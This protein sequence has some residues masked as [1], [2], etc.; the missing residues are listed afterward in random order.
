[1]S[2]YLSRLV[3][4]PKPQVMVAFSDDHLQHLLSNTCVLKQ[5]A[6]RPSA[7]CRPDH[8]SWSS[9]AKC[10]LHEI[11]LRGSP[12][13]MNFFETYR[14]PK[15]NTHLI[16]QRNSFE[17]EI[18]S[19]GS[20][21]GNISQISCPNRGNPHVRESRVLA[22]VRPRMQAAGLQCLKAPDCGCF[23]RPANTRVSR[24]GA[25]PEDPVTQIAVC[26]L[27]CIRPPALS[28][29]LHLLC[30]ETGRWLL[31]RERVVRDTRLVARVARE[32]LRFQLRARIGT[33]I[34]R[35]IFRPLKRSAHPRPP[36]RD[37]RPISLLRFFFLR[38]HDS[39]FLGNSLWT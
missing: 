5:D 19:G 27:F 13:Q 2:L 23:S 6:G 17:K 29:S 7:A 38:L 24:Y 37:G 28:P 31:T 32:I 34:L 30:S 11:S 21:A 1:M 3:A 25:F 8:Q 35:A 26:P 20:Q 4:L 33:R 10:F 18:P 9:F 12:F 14:I 16:F 36:L 15:N 22:P 39:N